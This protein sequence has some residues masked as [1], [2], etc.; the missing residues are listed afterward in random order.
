MRKD[1]IFMEK[2]YYQD[3]ELSRVASHEEIKNSYKKLV[4]KYHP[5]NNAGNPD[6]ESKLKKINEAYSVLSNPIKK[7]QYDNVINSTEN[8]SYRD[9]NVADD[10]ISG[11]FGNDIKRFNKKREEYLRFLDEI[12]PKFNKYGLNLNAARKNALNSTWSILDYDNFYTNKVKIERDLQRLEEF[13]K[14]RKGYLKFLDNMEPEFNKHKKTIKK[15]RE[16]VLNIS[17]YQAL[18]LPTSYFLNRKYDIEK[19]LRNLWKKFNEEQVFNK[20]R[21]EYLKFLDEIELEFNKYNKTI[22]KEKENVLNSSYS[23]EII[24]STI[25]Y[26]FYDKK[27]KIKSSLF[28]LEKEVREERKKPEFMQKLYQCQEEVEKRGIDF[29]EYLAKRHTNKDVIPLESIEKI[30]NSMALIDQ[31]N[32]NLFDFGIT[33]EEF[34][35]LRDKTL[36]EIKYSEL[37]VINETINKYLVNAKMTGN[38]DI[39]IINF[40]DSGRKVI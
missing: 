25:F 14:E 34:L 2:N 21:E 40:E 19:E 36:I 18:K 35:Q 7:Q 12:E 27:E 8:I 17:Y 24:P 20:E 9:D 37:V 32:T 26:Y 39:N 11:L 31:I 30:L 13:D 23:S 16:C 33:L 28:E 5:D 1:V 6:A 3:L 22:K 15:E 10:I 38:F 4:K 29:Q